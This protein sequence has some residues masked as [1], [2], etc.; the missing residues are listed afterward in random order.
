MLQKRTEGMVVSRTVLHAAAVRVADATL[1]IAHGTLHAPENHTVFQFAF[2]PHIRVQILRRLITHYHVNE[3]P[4]RGFTRP[5]RLLACSF[6]HACQV[7]PD[8]P[9][10]VGAVDINQSDA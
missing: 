5:A 4:H 8:G 3:R 9:E 10:S 1:P 2:K 7:L 6:S